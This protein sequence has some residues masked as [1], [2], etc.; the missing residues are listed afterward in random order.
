ML[1]GH[2]ARGL[3]KVGVGL[4]KDLTRLLVLKDNI[5]DL[6]APEVE[7]DSSHVDIEVSACRDIGGRLVD[8]KFLE[9]LGDS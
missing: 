5:A 8:V 7:A 1:Q 3:I 9:I 6:G 2:L 4:D